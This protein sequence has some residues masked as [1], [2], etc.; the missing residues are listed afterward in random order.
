M[1]KALRTAALVVGGIALIATGV[2][3]GI[4][5]ATGTT[6][7]S[8]LATIGLSTSLLAAASALATGLSL[9]ASLAMKAPPIAGNPTDFILDPQAPASYVMGRTNNSGAAIYRKEHPSPGKTPND[10]ETFVV[11]LSG[12]GP[13]EAI[14][15][16][17]A[18]DVAVTFDADGAAIGSD[19][20][21]WM[22]QKTQLG[23]CPEPS[24]L[25]VTAGDA[26]PPPDW[27]AAHKL[28]GY[29]A[30][31]WTL[32]YDSKG[33]HF[34]G[35]E[36]KPT[37]VLKG[38]KVYDP[39]QDSTYPGG[40]GPCR[41][42]DES[43][44]VW[45]GV[46]P[47]YPAGE[48]PYLHALT[49][50]L[51]RWQNG[52]R[53]MGIGAPLVG[54]DVAAFVEGAN[55][56]DANGWKIGGVQYS[57][58][59]KY[60]VLSNMLQAGGG[61]PISLG[62]KIS[63]FVNAPKVVLDTITI[64]DVT[65]R[66][67]AQLTQPRRDRINRIIPRYRSEDHKWEVVSAAPV[68]V[69]DYVAFDGGERTKEAD[70]P[71][72]QDVDQA[73]Q[74]ARYGIENAREFGPISLPLRLRWH[75][76]RPGDC[77]VV[78]IPEVGLVAQPVVLTNKTISPTSGLPS[79]TAR[80]ETTGKHAYALGQTGTPPPT[81]S[82]STYDPAVPAPDE[83]D[84]TL[85][86]VT[87]TDNGTSIPALLLTGEA[88]N[89]ITDAIL[90]EYRVAEVGLGDDDNWTGGT[91]EAPTIIRKEITGVTPETT[92]EVA[93]RY[94]VRGVIGARLILGPATAG[95]MVVG[96]AAAQSDLQ[97]VIDRIDAYGIP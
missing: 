82:A 4:A 19:Y 90:F 86:G 96:G 57:A 9:A 46:D 40:S 72:V 13:I 41:P 5:L 55:V 89:P 70:Y 44:Y 14:E 74:L 8:G 29:A 68:A 54:I 75:G 56:A 50:V 16:F 47:D 33:K 24:A 63:C 15:S 80:S 35:G 22:W 23:A 67:S 58:D 71:L 20:S 28:S 37:W 87:L 94:R 39:R 36:P 83:D 61:E 52:K 79:F 45:A 26:S 84:W 65:G 95:T 17:K 43:T 78:D 27:T 73:S 11:I 76:Y 92:Y 66:V 51:G 60:D 21:S 3:A 6:F 49:W 53:V 32:R 18:D 12:A 30:A 59:N 48:N 85:A 88:S 25:M 77:V 7:A 91:V 34:Q 1:A 62:A 31:M 93:I 42:Y 2:G 38:V 10:H 81:P 97:T 69:D 64:A